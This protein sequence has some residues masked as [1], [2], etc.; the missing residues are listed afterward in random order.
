MQYVSCLSLDNIDDSYYFCQIVEFLFH[1][2]R[3]QIPRSVLWIKNFSL[4]RKKSRIDK[5]CRIDYI[6]IF[7][8]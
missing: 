3:C 7:Y 1:Q 6:S 8:V 2:L 4:E 5:Q